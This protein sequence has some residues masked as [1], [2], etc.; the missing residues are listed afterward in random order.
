MVLAVT[1]VPWL[2][3]SR[4]QDDLEIRGDKVD[5]LLVLREVWELIGGVLQPG[6]LQ[7]VMSLSSCS[8][9]N[10]LQVLLQGTALE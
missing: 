6:G 2:T 8:E 10:L 9:C 3:L 7:F 5:Y 1:A 4:P